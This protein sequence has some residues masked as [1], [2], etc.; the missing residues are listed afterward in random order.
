M[1]E[2]GASLG[3]PKHLV[4]RQPFPG[5]GLAIRVLCTDGV[6][7]PRLSAVELA[8]V[9]ECVKLYTKATLSFVELPVRTV[10]VQG[11][12]RS[13]KAA[14]ALTLPKRCASSSE[15]RALPPRSAG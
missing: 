6:T 2:L 12:C 10:G 15:V 14:I 5:P 8:K 11:D 4:W 13:Y 1:R 7:P 9:A 3:L